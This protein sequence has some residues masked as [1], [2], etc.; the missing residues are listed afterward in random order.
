MLPPDLPHTDPR[1]EEAFAEA[2]EG[3]EEARSRRKRRRVV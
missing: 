1:L 3:I 2:A